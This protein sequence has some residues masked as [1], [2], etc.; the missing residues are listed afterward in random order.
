MSDD[1]LTHSSSHPGILGGTCQPIDQEPE[2]VSLRPEHLSEYVGQNEVV[3][4][5]IR[6]N[7]TGAVGDGKIFV[8][9]LENAIRVRTDEEGDE[10]LDEA[11]L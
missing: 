8:C 1:V 9:P 2:V 5:L 10:A 3:E 6:I 4:T 7:Q 11:I